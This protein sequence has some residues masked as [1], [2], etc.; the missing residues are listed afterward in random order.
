MILLYHLATSKKAFTVILLLFA[1]SC[2]RKEPVVARLGNTEITLEEFKSAYIEIIKQPNVFD[3][4]E[5]REQFLAELIDRRLLAQEAERAGLDK[6]ERLIY[7][8]Q[9]NHDKNLREAHYRQVIKPKIKYTEAEMQS[10]YVHLNEERRV[11]H[12]YSETRGGADSLYQLLHNGIPWDDLAQGVFKDSRLSENGGDLGWVSWEQMEY[13]LATAAFTLTLNQYSQPIASSY[14]WHILQVLDFR[15]TPL[16]SQTNYE[17]QRDKAKMILETKLGDKTALLYISHLMAGKRIKVHPQIL[18]AVGQQLGRLLQRSPSPADQMHD[19][20]LSDIEMQQ[21]DT[22]LWDIREKPLA[23]IDGDIL[24]VGEFI[25]AL[26][27]VPY[28]AAHQ[29]LRTAL[30]YVLRDR[31]LTMEARAMGLEKNDEVRLKT[32]QYK[33]NRL[34]MIMRLHLLANITIDDE[35]L[36]NYYTAHYAAKYPDMKFADARELIKSQVLTEKRSQRLREHLQQLRHT[37]SIVKNV[38]PIHSWY[39]ARRDRANNPASQ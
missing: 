30:N 25:S 38:E 14:G 1:F 9:A 11:R 17:L 8:I 33:Q 29:S 32:A 10:A 36:Q 39:D 26:N 37:I 27:Y 21:L 13:D 24:T 35:D 15:K 22:S 18:H 6:D 31:A 28:Q 34:Q 12:L 19:E 5:L 3:S 7:R 2:A 23:E 20:Q 16:L 4:K